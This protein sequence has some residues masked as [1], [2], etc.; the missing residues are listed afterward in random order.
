[1][2]ETTRKPSGKDKAGGGDNPPPVR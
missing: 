1:M 2:N